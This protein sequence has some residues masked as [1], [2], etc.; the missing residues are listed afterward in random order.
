LAFFSDFIALKN[1]KEQASV[2]PLF[3]ALSTA[4]VAESGLKERWVREPVSTFLY[5]END[6]SDTEEDYND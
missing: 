6:Y 3:S 1:L 2:L 4:M 5:R